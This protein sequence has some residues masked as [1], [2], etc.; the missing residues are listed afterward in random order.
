MQTKFSTLNNK[1]NILVASI[2]ISFVLVF[3]N[4]NSSNFASCSHGAE[5]MG[6]P[7]QMDLIQPSGIP[8]IFIYDFHHKLLVLMTCVGTF[9][10]YILLRC[11]YVY[12]HKRNNVSMPFN[13]HSALEI[14]WT[15]IPATLIFCVGT[16]SIDLIN[17]FGNKAIVERLYTSKPVQLIVIAHQWYWEYLYDLVLIDNYFK[18]GVHQSFKLLNSIESHFVESEDSFK[19][20]TPDKALYL[21][22]RYTFG[23]AE[24]RLLNTPAD[25]SQV[26]NTLFDNSSFYYLL[27][28]DY[29]VFLPA[30]TDIE[31]WCTSVDVIH[32]WAVPALG[33]KLD[34]IPGK[35]NYL[36][37]QGL[38]GYNYGQCSELCG[39]NHGFMPI[40][41]VMV[42]RD[43]WYKF[44]SMLIYRDWF[45]I[46]L[47]KMKDKDSYF[48]GIMNPEYDQN[49]QTLLYQSISERSKGLTKH[50]LGD[51]K[52]SKE[53]FLNTHQFL[54]NIKSIFFQPY[55]L[56]QTGIIRPKNSDIFQYTQPLTAEN[57]TGYLN[58][59][60]YID[61][62]SYN[63]EIYNTN[64]DLYYS[65]FQKRY[66]AFKYVFMYDFFFKYHKI[67]TQEGFD[68]FFSLYS[69]LLKNHGFPMTSEFWNPKNGN[70]TVSE[71][72]HNLEIETQEELINTA[73]SIEGIELFDNS[74]QLESFADF[75]TFAKIRRQ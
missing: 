39:V 61:F 15:L 35:I 57:V 31:V 75:D 16:I 2:F 29:P 70:I 52:G 68:K 60:N 48:Y 74:L 53:E 1:L 45:K 65:E 42:K 71:T 63:K 17:K 20:V 50:L 44:V 49:D 72:L 51:I 14:V 13:H 25:R 26:I 59:Y 30:F 3:M 12:S 18:Y 6:K 21:G 7:W 73:S 69:Y 38:P 55:E 43:V 46:I 4:S 36:I 10:I 54:Q 33:I 19:L 34:C 24:S 8:A 62:Y 27:S 32:S 5:Y 41:V 22:D 37:F 67:H 9:T 66:K 11:C 58:F 64:P 23:Y 28:T 47:R 56:T 40:E